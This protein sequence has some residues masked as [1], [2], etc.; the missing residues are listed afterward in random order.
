M[1]EMSTILYL[2]LENKELVYLQKETSKIYHLFSNCTGKPMATQTPITKDLRLCKNC[3]R[4]QDS[5][6][7]K[8]PE[9]EDVVTCLCLEKKTVFQITVDCKHATVSCSCQRSQSGDVCNHSQFILKD[10]L[11]LPSSMIDD[12]FE[13]GGLDDHELD[14]FRTAV[15]KGLVFHSDRRCSACRQYIHGVSVKSMD[16][17]YHQ[18]CYENVKLYLK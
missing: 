4:R 14:S 12:L 5:S 2:G 18:Q 8:K 6:D 16:K 17:I 3:Q 1:K 11:S 10:I 9:Q 7:V 15:E 13:Y